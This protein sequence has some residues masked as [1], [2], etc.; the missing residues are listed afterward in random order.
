M[1]WKPKWR[2]GIVKV[3]CLDDHLEFYN[4]DWFQ[5]WFDYI[6]LV[7]INSWLWQFVV[8]R[9]IFNRNM[10]LRTDHFLG[11]DYDN[12]SLVYRLIE[13]A[14]VPEEDLVE[15]LLNNIIVEW[16]MN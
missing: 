4:E 12:Y 15:F 14:L 1:G 5:F 11:Q 6:Y 10:G 3:E 13:S 16:M 8:D 2:E 7:S 9:K